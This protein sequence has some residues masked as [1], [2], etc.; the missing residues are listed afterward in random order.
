MKTTVCCHNQCLPEVIFHKGR[1]YISKKTGSI[2]LCT[3]YSKDLIG[4]IVHTTPTSVTCVGQYTDGLALDDFI[5][6]TG[7]VT[8]TEEW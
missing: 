8:L 3:Y 1:L 7:T 6:F 5:P 4:V 2:V